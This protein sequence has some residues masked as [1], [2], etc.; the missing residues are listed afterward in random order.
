[1]ICR[2]FKSSFESTYMY[3]CQI[4]DGINQNAPRMWPS[5]LKRRL[6]LLLSVRKQL[7]YDVPL[8]VLTWYRRHSFG[9]DRGLWT[10]ISFW[11]RSSFYPLDQRSNYDL[12]ITHL[13]SFQESLRAGHPFAIQVRAL[14]IFYLLKCKKGIYRLRSMYGHGLL[15]SLNLRHL[16]VS[17]HQFDLKCWKNYLVF[18][19]SQKTTT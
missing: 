10:P 19:W 11:D 15:I 13:Q 9:E 7:W 8:S 3:V 2:I 16:V 6:L 5:L 14:N 18:V 17:S 4:V 1:M 12:T